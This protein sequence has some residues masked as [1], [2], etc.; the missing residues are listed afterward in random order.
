MTRLYIFAEGQTEQTFGGTMLKKHLAAFG[1]YVQGPILIAHARKKGV[2]HRGGGRRYSPIKNDI[3]RFLKQEKNPDV[4]FTTMI[5][6][7]ALPV[8]FPGTDEAESLRHSPYDRVRKLEE[9]FATDI[10]DP[11][12]RPTC[13]IPHIQLHEYEAILFCRPREFSSFFGN[14]SKQIEQLE[15]I[16]REYESPELIDDGQH[17]A[18]SKRISAIIPDYHRAKRVAG[19]QIAEEIGLPT[20]RELCPHF[21]AWLKQLESLPNS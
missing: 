19:P 9:C 20:V 4:Y 11:H 13:F 3:L 16:V 1:V 17:T 15:K 5:D 10:D 8:D 14:C 21:D 7:Y 6:L 2:T 18:P 12:G